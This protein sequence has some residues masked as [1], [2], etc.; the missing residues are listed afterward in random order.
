MVV[1]ST[2]YMILASQ[3]NTVFQICPTL[4][5]INFPSV[6]SS[7]MLKMLKIS[8]MANDLDCVLLTP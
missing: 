8:V 6:V 5:G 7:I 3:S 4:G 2:C 1:L